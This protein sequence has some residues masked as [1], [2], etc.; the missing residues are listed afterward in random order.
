M[1]PS[2]RPSIKGRSRLL[3]NNP[4]Y[5]DLG[6][7]RMTQNSPPLEGRSEAE[8]SLAALNAELEA[9]IDELARANV[10]LYE[11]ARQKS[12]FVANMSHELRTPL[13]SI[14]GFADVLLGQLKDTATPEQIKYLQ[15]IR[16]G[17]YRLLEILSE[18]L[19]FARLES[20]TARVHL[21]PVSVPGLV[22]EVITNL[23]RVV[24]KKIDLKADVPGNL[25]T[26]IADEIKLTQILQN[27]GSNAV[28]FTP[29]GGSVTLSARL[30][31]K[32]LTLAV[33]DTGV[34]IA[35]KDQEAIFKRFRQLD[36]GP[37]RRYEG[38]GLGLYIVQGLVGML[39]GKLS[40]QSAPGEGSTF[41]VAIPVEILEV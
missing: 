14:I 18:L 5:D 7:L 41:T 31:C 38:V 15:N 10:E 23:S 37:E 12:E 33:A 11:T 17:G 39:G 30:D 3:P 32:T 13:N 8:A 6:P 24:R 19:T 22:S 27:L 21:G 9:K 29:D 28:K 35:E 25:P 4:L 2:R 20:G 26:V 34:G 36:T 16:R 1:R 40:L